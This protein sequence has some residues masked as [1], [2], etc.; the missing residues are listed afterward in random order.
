M[1]I[2]EILSPERVIERLRVSKKA[3]LL[4][5]LAHRAAA[6]TGLEETQIIAGLDARD[7]LGSTG[8]GQGIALPH[9][10][11]N[12][13]GRPYGLFARLEQPLDFDAIDGKAVDLVFLLLVPESSDREH[14]TAL[15]AISRKLRDCKITSR[16]RDSATAAEIYEC[17]VNS[18]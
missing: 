14:M 5:Q 4:E 6:D 8:I 15:A 7:R 13:L 18:F 17:L 2:G 16:L 11:I 1:N 10:R 9:A 3:E 12:G